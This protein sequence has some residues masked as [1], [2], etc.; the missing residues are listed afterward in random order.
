MD[1]KGKIYDFNGIS[2]PRAKPARRGKKDSLHEKQFTV[3][4]KVR[5]PL[6]LQ[7]EIFWS[8][9]S[10]NNQP[11]AGCAYKRFGGAWSGTR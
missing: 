9:G 3:M 6:S 10:S 2:D 8:G 4:R 1:L 7:V 11:D 5:Q